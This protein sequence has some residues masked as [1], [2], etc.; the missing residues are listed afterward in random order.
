MLNILTSKNTFR[1]IN[2]VNKNYI[3]NKFHKKSTNEF[4]HEQYCPVCGNTFYYQ[5]T[6][7]LIEKY[8]KQ[9]RWSNKFQE[10]EVCPDDHC[11]QWNKVFKYAQAKK[12][13]E[14]ELKALAVLS[15]PWFWEKYK[16]AKNRGL[17]S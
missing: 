13:A 15:K 5:L 14:A 8:K 1:N 2:P 17:V 3:G 6:P 10:V 4:G 9:N 16:H 12:Q 11:I 7:D